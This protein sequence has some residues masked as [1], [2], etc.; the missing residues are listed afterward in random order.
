MCEEPLHFP[1]NQGKFCV[2]QGLATVHHDHPRSGQGSELQT[3]CL[4]ET[5]LHAI[6]DDGIA[7]GFGDGKTD[8][9]PN[10]LLRLFE[11][12]CCEIRAGEAGTL[13][14]HFAEVAAAENPDTLRKTEWG[15]SERAVNRRVLRLSDQ[16]IRYSD[17][18]G[19]PCSRCGASPLS[20][21]GK[22]SLI[23]PLSSTS[24]ST[25]P[26]VN[27]LPNSSSS[28]SARRIVS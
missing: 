25:R 13:V 7:Q 3:H 8:F 6:S 23:S 28:A 4:T 21:G 24:T 10:F 27:S 1:L 12:E 22:S 19:S 11:T 2:K 16:L 18:T 15:Q 26:P 17:R 20:L 5:A 9:G 14:I